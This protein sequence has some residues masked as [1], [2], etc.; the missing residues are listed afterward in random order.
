M[1]NAKK[2]NA[3]YFAPLVPNYHLICWWQVWLKE[4]ALYERCPKGISTLGLE[5]TSILCP[6]RDCVRNTDLNSVLESAR[7]EKRQGRLHADHYI[8][9]FCYFGGGRGPPKHYSTII[10][11]SIR[12]RA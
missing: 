8:I 6:W 5:L 10:I 9:I 7:G 3:F 12:P 4:K 1:K 11:N 2:G